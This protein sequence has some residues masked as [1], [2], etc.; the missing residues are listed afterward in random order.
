MTATGPRIPR[1]V[2]QARGRAI[3][4][5]VAELKRTHEA[6]AEPD[7]PDVP[8]AD[9]VPAEDPAPD[10]PDEQPA[11]TPEPPAPAPTADEDED[12]ALA[13]K[14]LARMERRRARAA[15]AP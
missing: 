7:A 2:A 3:L 14:R 13:L 9:T 12:E 8:P 1:D 10:T 5:A 6:W 4:D 15:T 11:P